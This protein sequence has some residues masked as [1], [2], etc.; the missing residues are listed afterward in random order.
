MRLNRRLQKA[1]AVAA[2]ATVTVT[3]LPTTTFASDYEKHW[4]HA[5][6]DKWSQKEVLKG[7]EDGSFKPNATVTRGELAAILV[8]VFGLNEVAG[9]TEYKD[10]LATKWYAGDVAKVSAAGLMNDYE[11][12]TFK[13]EQPATREEAAYAVAK[14]Y[15]VASKDKTSNFKDQAQISDWAEDEIVAL[16]AGNYLHGTPDGTFRPQATLTRAEAVTMVDK[17]TADLIN[18][19]GVY[20]QDVEGNL[21]VNT[22]GVE[23]KDM[24]ITGNLYLAE[25]IGE[26]EVKLT[27]VTVLG[28]VI[29]EGGSV[30]TIKVE[31]QSK[32]NNILVDKAGKK[33]VRL[34]FGNLVQVNGTVTLE[35][36]TVLEGNA[37]SLK[38][39]V[40]DGAKEVQLVGTMKIEKVTINK[41]TELALVDGPIIQLVVI[42]KEAPA[43]IIRG[44]GTKGTIKKIII[45]ANNVELKKGFKYNK[46]YITIADGVTGTKF[47]ESGGGGGGGGSS[48]VVTQSK[49][50]L[51]SLTVNTTEGSTTV[52]LSSSTTINVELSNEG[53][54]VND[55]VVAK[56]GDAITSMV[57]NGKDGKGEVTVLAAG[58]STK[59]TLGEPYGADMF[60]AQLSQNYTTVKSLIQK[61]V[62]ET[63]YKQVEAKMNK[64]YDRLMA[65]TATSV[66]VDRVLELVNEA[67]AEFDTLDAN[68]LS[69]LQAKIDEALELAKV[70]NIEVAGLEN[71]SEGINTVT[72]K[73]RVILEQDGKDSNA[74]TVNV[75]YK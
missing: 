42:N 29:V 12:G 71:V 64:V 75:T 73:T 11:D 4:A 49:V 19:A 3:A 68:Q 43:T 22:T 55:T 57:V 23:L 17:I 53:V 58:N 21:V 36:S 24:T 51:K 45:Y 7:Y 56:S 8:R 67:K 66:E 61:V 26:G 13:P 41:T 9:A 25:G 6:I 30:N 15:R 10:V 52:D 14:A 35:S 18:V 60:K 16:V 20:S 5:A 33:P 72:V 46:D 47:P 37:L 44:R 38:E 28:D 70:A 32:L 59:L 74:Y 62:S 50:A 2:L 48:T 54:K 34:L 63:T 40:I 31:G 65:S 39:V 69:K 27:N 1:L